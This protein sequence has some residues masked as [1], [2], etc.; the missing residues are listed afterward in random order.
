M[1]IFDFNTNSVTGCSKVKD[2]CI[3]ALKVYDACRQQDCLERGIVGPARAATCGTFVQE[4]HL[5]RAK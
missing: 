1:G 5:S 2:E 4:L 3:I